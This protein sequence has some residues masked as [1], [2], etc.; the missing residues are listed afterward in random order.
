MKVAVTWQMC[1]YVDID[2]P[3]MESA[4]KY[5][6]ENSDC[7]KLPK[8]GIY[9]DGSFELSSDDVEEMKIMAITDSIIKKMIGD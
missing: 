9:V 1:G 8:D 4:M 6:E 3:T 7:I 5:F 2:R